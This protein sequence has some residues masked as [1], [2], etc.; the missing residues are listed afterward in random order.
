M[1]ISSFFIGIEGVLVFLKSGLK[2]FCVVLMVG[3]VCIPVSSIPINRSGAWLTEIQGIRVLHLEGSSYTMGYDYGRLLHDEAMEDFRGLVDVS[4]KLGYNINFFLDVWDQVK[5]FIPE[6]YI[7]EMQGLADALNQSLEMVGATH[8]IPT[9]FHCSSFSAWNNATVD[10]KLMHARSLDFPLSIKDPESG[11]YLQDN[12]VLIVREPAAGYASL[13]P[14]FSGLIGSLGGFNDQGI[15]TG[16]L[17]CWSNDEIKAGIPMMFRQRMILDHAD[18][19]TK[20]MEIID[21]NKTC[22]WNFIISDAKI[23]VGYAVE[24]TT[25]TSYMGSWDDATEATKPFYKIPYVVRRTNIFINTSTAAMQRSIYDPRWFPVLGYISG[26]SRLGWSIVPAFLPWIH[27]KALSNGIEQEYGLLDLNTNMD[28]LRGVYKSA[29]F[30]LFH[31]FVRLHFYMTL[32]QW[33]VD[34]MSGDMLISFANKKSNAFDEP[35]HE[36]NLYKLLEYVP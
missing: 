25:H 36:F 4:K 22:G 31:L 35:V 17:S 28:V 19:I 7:L 34:P 16:V 11:H 14:S 8:M 10:G 20:A 18:T 6:E 27:Y 32:Q 23:P 12:A 29:Y 1:F 26:R 3:C 30:T 21:L 5:P 15:A 13:D 2:I 24:Q 9:F 33:V